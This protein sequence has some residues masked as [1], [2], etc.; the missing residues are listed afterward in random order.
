MFILKMEWLLTESKCK[1]A[2]Q[3]Q[4]IRKVGI[5]RPQKPRECLLPTF[6]SHFMDYSFSHNLLCYSVSLAYL[7]VAKIPRG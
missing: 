5:G 1:A 2:P 6:T 7:T 3:S 4:E